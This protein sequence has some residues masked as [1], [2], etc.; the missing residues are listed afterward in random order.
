MPA[1]WVSPGCKRPW[2]EVTRCWPM[3]SHAPANCGKHGPDGLLLAGYWA[4]CVVTQ[5][6]PMVLASHCVS[7]FTDDDMILLMMT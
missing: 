5:S 6:A 3:H 1:A 7:L 4:G 2:A